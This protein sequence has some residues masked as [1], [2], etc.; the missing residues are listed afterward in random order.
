M[1]DVSIRTSQPGEPGIVLLGGSFN[2]AHAGHFRIA[3]EAGEALAPE[4]ILFIPCGLPPH[5]PAG[6]LLPF[7]LR[8]E[9]LR[10]GIADCAAAEKGADRAGGVSGKREES[11]GWSVPLR[12]EVCL[13]EGRRAGPSYTV[14]TL[15]ALR[16]QYPGRRLFFVLGAE[17]LPG[18]DTWSRWRRIPELADLVALPRGGEGRARFFA[19]A[20]RLWPGARPVEPPFAAVDAALRLPS[21]G[22]LLYLPQPSLAISS[23]LVRGRMLGGRS[24]DFLVPRGVQRLLYEHRG[25]ALALWRGD[26]AK[27]GVIEAETTLSGEAILINRPMDD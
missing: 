1:Q 2:P 9:M 25:T 12:M 16:G 21:G 14:D 11:G 3:I 23:S 22:R 13:E 19:A 26:A 5:K 27:G 20:G 24:L 8:V 18:L 4:R 15:E 6:A 17:D 10:A 7:D